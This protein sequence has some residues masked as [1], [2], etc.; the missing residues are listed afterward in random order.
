[1][2]SIFSLIHPETKTI[3]IKSP[4]KTVLISNLWENKLKYFRFYFWHLFLLALFLPVSGYNKLTAY[5]LCF[6]VFLSVDILVSYL[7]SDFFIRTRKF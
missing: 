7:N 1:M 5:F 2:A 4:T 6:C 3:R